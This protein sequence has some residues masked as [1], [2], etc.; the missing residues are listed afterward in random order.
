[1]NRLADADQVLGLIGRF[2][3]PLIA[4]G[5]TRRVE[6]DSANEPGE[7]G[8]GYDEGRIAA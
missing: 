8:P 5:V 6:A 4:R 2:Y 7:S 3:D 1:M